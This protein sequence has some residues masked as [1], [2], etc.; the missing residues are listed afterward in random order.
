MVPDLQKNVTNEGCDAG[1]QVAY[2]MYAKSIVPFITTIREATMVKSIF[3]TI[4]VLLVLF[5]SIGEEALAN[6]H[7]EAALA[8]CLGECS[9]FR[10]VIMRTGCE[11]GCAIGY[12]RC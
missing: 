11:V 10:T 4:T 6:S 5:G 1:I 12:L 3:L 2:T 7:C 9:N 8:Y